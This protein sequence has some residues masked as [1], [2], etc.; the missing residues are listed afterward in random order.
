MNLLIVKYL[1]FVPVEEVDKQNGAG[2]LVIGISTDL[3]FNECIRV[4]ART[5]I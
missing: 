2:I 4:S 1:F 5:W 3:S